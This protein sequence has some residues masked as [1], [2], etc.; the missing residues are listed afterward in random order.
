MATLTGA[1]LRAATAG[2]L[3]EGVALANDWAHFVRKVDCGEYAKYASNWNANRSC[4]TKCLR[5]LR[6]CISKIS[7][8][9]LAERVKQVM[10]A[11]G[12]GRLWAVLEKSYIKDWGWTWSRAAIEPGCVLAGQ[13]P[14]ENDNRGTKLLLRGTALL[15]TTP[16]QFADNTL[17]MKLSVMT[18]NLL[19]IDPASVSSVAPVDDSFAPAT[20]LP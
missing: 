8:L 12:E 7:F 17:P 6:A 13:Q 5:D 15:K 2:A 10:V 3:Y 1:A 19:T 4:V 18:E 20:H 16:Q 14:V 9:K 11:L